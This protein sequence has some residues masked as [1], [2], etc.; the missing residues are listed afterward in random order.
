MKYKI[1]FS[2][3]EANLKEF[4]YVENVLKSGWLTTGSVAKQFEDNFCKFIGSKYSLTVSSCTA[5]LHLS[6]NAIS[7]K[8]GDKIIN[9][10]LEIKMFLV[11]VFSRLIRKGND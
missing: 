1:P 4:E 8:K 5:A 11:Q 7:V 6:L 10:R 9:S 2:K 3:V